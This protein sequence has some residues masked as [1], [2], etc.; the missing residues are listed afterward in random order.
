MQPLI[1]R[2]VMLKDGFNSLVSLFL[3]VHVSDSL[4]HKLTVGKDMLNI[5]NIHI[6]ILYFS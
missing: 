5:Y 1:C 6:N 4:K 3:N 2:C